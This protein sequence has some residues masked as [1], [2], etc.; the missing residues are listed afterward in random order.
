M[1]II[2]LNFKNVGVFLILAFFVVVSVGCSGTPTSLENKS[3]HHTNTGFRN[4]PYVET[5][6]S[7]GVMFVL[8]RIWGSAFHP[9]IPE[10]H[11]IPE[12]ETIFQLEEF[13]ENNTIT[14][15]GHST[16]LL[17]VDGKTILTDPFLTNRASPVSF[18]GGITRYVPPGISIENLPVINA[19]II[20]HNHYDHLDKETIQTLGNQPRYLVPLKLK[21]WFV[22]IGIDAK[23]VNEFDWWDTKIIENLSVTATPSQ[24]WSARGLFDRFDSL[25]AA[26]HIEIGD[27]NFWFA[28]DTGYNDVQFKEIGERF[29]NIDLALIPIGAYAPRWFMKQQHVNPE[30]AIQIHKDIGAKRSIGMHWGTFQLTAEP[31]REPIERLEQAVSNGALTEGEFTTLAIGETLFYSPPLKGLSD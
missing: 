14:W 8:R 24:H 10:G 26:W 5:A 16:F 3:N 6:S 2:I 27:F 4:S 7:K 30:E 11:R 23:Q 31:I 25:W 15:L 13:S 20:S 18:I 19:I 12:N 1:E 28:G 9:T 21:E 22:D 17:K 29:A